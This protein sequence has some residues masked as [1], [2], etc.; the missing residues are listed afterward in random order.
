MAAGWAKTDAPAVNRH[1]LKLRVVGRQWWWEVRYPGT[2]AVTANEL[3]VRSMIK[4][5]TFGSI[6]PPAARALSLVGG[7]RTP[8][9]SHPAI[10][11]TSAIP[12]TTR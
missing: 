9:R 3:I 4:R 7:V 8:D 12:R 5:T 10:A 2:T 1:D 11:M 6:P